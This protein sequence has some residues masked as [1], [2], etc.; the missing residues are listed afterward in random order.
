[1]KKPF[2]SRWANRQFA[3]LV[4]EAM[5]IENI[6]QIQAEKRVLALFESGILDNNSQDDPDTLKKIM[7]FMRT[8]I[9]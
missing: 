4:K 7:E 9:D 5:E 8:P 3:L 6:D 1:M 2:K